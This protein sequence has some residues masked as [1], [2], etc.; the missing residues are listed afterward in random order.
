MTN[1]DKKLIG[2]FN[3]ISTFASYY[4]EYNKY[5]NLCEFDPHN[6]IAKER[7]DDY[8]QLATIELNHLKQFLNDEIEL[9][10]FKDF[11]GEE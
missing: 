8:K 2:T 4:S 7:R 10:V 3:L 9:A 5:K 6:K 11:Y 1:E